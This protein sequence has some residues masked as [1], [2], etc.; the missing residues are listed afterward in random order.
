[1]GCWKTPKTIKKVR[2]IPLDFLL[3]V[4]YYQPYTFNKSLRLCME[5]QR[6]KQI[7]VDQRREINEILSQQ[8]IIE[9][10]APKEKLLKF[11]RYPNV[12]LITGVRRCG[13]SIFS[14]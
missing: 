2:K 10:E 1:L 8:R 9:R 11:L 7:V 6:L 14:L 4:Y 5:I 13:K 3:K 12:L